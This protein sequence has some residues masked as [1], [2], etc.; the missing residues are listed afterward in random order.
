[1]AGEEEAERERGRQK[2]IQSRLW[3]VSAEPNAGFKLTNQEIM[4]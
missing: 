2:R 3:S 1:M 4:T